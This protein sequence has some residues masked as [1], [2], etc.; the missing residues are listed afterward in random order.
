MRSRYVVNAWQPQQSLLFSLCCCFTAVRPVLQADSR[1]Q[2]SALAEL[3]ESLGA[4]GVTLDLQYSS[5]IHDREIRY[6][7]DSHMKQLFPVSFF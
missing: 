2:S 1:Q 5:T 7:C 3:K 4:Q 6:S